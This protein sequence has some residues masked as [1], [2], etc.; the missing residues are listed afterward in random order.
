MPRLLRSFVLTCIVWSLTAACI[1]QAP[2]DAAK[3]F[4]ANCELCHGTDGS[5][6]TGPGKAF[7]AQDLRS[8]ETQKQSDAQLTETITRGR[9]KM[10]AF[11]TK[12]K[13]DDITKLVAYVRTLAL[14]K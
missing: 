11:G 1:A 4:K 2:A 14:K 12:I 3:I 9:E 10:P 13:A 7:H 5:G 8:V 6:N